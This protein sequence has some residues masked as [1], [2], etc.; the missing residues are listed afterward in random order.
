VLALSPTLLS[1]RRGDRARGLDPAGAGAITAAMVLL[2]YGITQVPQAGWISPQTIGLLAVSVGLIALFAVVEARSPA[3]LLPLR[4]LRSRTL[5]AGN[6]IMLVA[7]L[8]VDGMLFVLTLYAQQVLGYSAVQFGLALTVMTIAS[9]G[10]SYLAQH[11]VTRIGPRPVAATGLALI[12]GSCLLL[13]RISVGGTFVGDLLPGL[14]LFGLGM[15]VTFVAGSVASLTD[16]PERDSGV[17]SGLQ[18]TSFTLGTALGVAV[19]STIATARTERLLASHHVTPAALTGGYQ[20]A[21]GAAAVV[22]GMGLVIV[23]ITTGGRPSRPVHTS[24]GQEDV[25]SEF[26]NRSGA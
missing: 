3:P 5:V 7:G 20:A 22:A 16:V 9:I 23:L 8:A 21:F 2:V 14:L 19:L 1:C 17:A 12:A 11:V 24:R 15:G 26:D 10:G 25:M 18:N 4:I 6:V 13:T